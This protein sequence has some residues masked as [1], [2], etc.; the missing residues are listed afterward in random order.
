S[1]NENNSKDNQDDMKD[2]LKDYN[3]MFGTNFEMGQIDAYNRNVNDRLARKSKQYQA[4]SQQLDIV[5][6]VDRLLTG[7]DSP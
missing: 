6:V 7:F 3:A 1:Q 5:I 2:S 4:P